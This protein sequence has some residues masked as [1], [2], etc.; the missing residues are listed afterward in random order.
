M[1]TKSTFIA[2]LCAFWSVGASASHVPLLIWSSGSLPPVSPP[3]G[4]VTLHSELGSYLDAALGSAPQT[5]LLFLQEKLS[6]EDFTVYGGVYGNS[7]DGAFKNVEAALRSR[8][9]VFPAVDW[10]PSASVLSILEEKLGVAPLLVAPDA[11]EL[12][13][14]TATARLL[15]V[16]LPYCSRDEPCRERLRSNDKV[17]GRVLNSLEAKDVPFTAFFTGLQPSRVISE[18]SLSAPAGRSLLQA[19]PPAP[20]VKPPIMF[21]ISSGPCIML[22]AQNLKVSFIKPENWTDLASQTLTT[23][24][25][26]CNE[27]NAVLVLNNGAGVTLSFSMSQRFFPVSARRWFSLDSVQLLRNNASASFSSRSIYAPAEYSFHCQS[28][29]SFRDALLVHDNRLNASAWM[30]DLVDFQ[31][32]GFGL[33][34]GTNFSYASDCAG[35]FTPGIW[36]GLITALLMLLIFVYGL[37]MILQLNTMDRFDDPKGPCIS[38]P[39]SE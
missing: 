14:D 29:S 31:I 33:N 35:F 13:T 30:L 17:I 28:V 32:Q 12:E 3:A 18:P 20:A 27:T 39:Q 9:A 22:W 25:S 34:N 38:V 10:S 21:N 4:H 1:A 24:G 19:P 16:R 11:A 5:V 26:M 37:N 2:C 36:M 15:L 7:E 6:Q 23:A 8:S